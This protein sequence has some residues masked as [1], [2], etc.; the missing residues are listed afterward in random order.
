MYRGRLPENV[1]DHIEFAK[2]FSFEQ[3]GRRL[4]MFVT[5][6]LTDR[7]IGMSILRPCSAPMI[8]R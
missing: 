6:A 8:H 7:L 1:M 3:C 5:V 2:A 4:L